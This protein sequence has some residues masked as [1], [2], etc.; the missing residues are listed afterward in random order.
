MMES[1]LN[2][3][4]KYPFLKREPE[5][6]DRLSHYIVI[7]VFFVFSAILIIVL[8][9]KGDFSTINENNHLLAIMDSLNEDLDKGLENIQSVSSSKETDKIIEGL[10]KNSFQST[11]EI[12]FA[13]LYL[14]YDTN[15]SVSY[16]Y[17]S[18][19]N[20]FN[21]IPENIVFD[22]LDLDSNWSGMISERMKLVELGIMNN[23]KIYAYNFRTFAGCD[24]YLMVA[25]KN[26]FLLLNKTTFLWTI[27]LLF[28]GT[29]LTAL[30]MIYLLINKFKK[31]YKKLVLGLE[32][33]AS[34]NMSYHPESDG[35]KELLR[36][37]KASNKI[38]SMI[39]DDHQKI[40]DYSLKLRNASISLNESQSLLGIIIENSQVVCLILK[41]SPHSI[42]KQI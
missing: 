41:H 25:V 8:Y 33:T 29:V 20:E 36:L 2:K 11:P 38:S 35:G 23:H 31:P 1:I 22:D 39:R 3:L 4:Y 34:G 13:Q 17:Q 27:L 15:P 6:M 26:K 18:E 37:V 10:L 24:A 42:G 19:S 28:L 5:L 32:S 12:K 7:Q 30:L 21:N 40:E 16:F 14:R 9:P